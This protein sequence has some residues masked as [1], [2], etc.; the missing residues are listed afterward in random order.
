L[1]S[2]LTQTLATFI[3]PGWGYYLDNN[4]MGMGIF[5]QPDLAGNVVEHNT[6]ANNRSHGIYPDRARNTSIKNNIQIRNGSVELTLPQ[7]QASG[8]ARE[9][10]AVG[11]PPLAEPR[12]HILINRSEMAKTYA[13]GSGSFYD[14]AG[15]A[16]GA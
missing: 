13:L 9:R 14:A 15:L 12:S 11:C 7:W 1:N 10:N 4:Q 8:A 3:Q 16:I 6:F 2:D 5:F